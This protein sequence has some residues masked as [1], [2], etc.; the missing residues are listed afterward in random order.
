PAETLDRWMA[1]LATAAATDA[2]LTLIHR[3]D[4]LSEVLSALSGRFGRV[5]VLPVHPRANQPAHR[6]LVSAVKG[7]RAPLAIQH[8]L[9]LHQADGSYLPE[10]EAVLREGAAL[11]L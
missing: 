1:F 5:R 10:I 4:A 11:T 8:A 9:V 6:I 2:T 3:A 7:S